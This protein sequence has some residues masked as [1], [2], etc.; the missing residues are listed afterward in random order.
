MLSAMKTTSAAAGGQRDSPKAVSDVA[1]AAGMLAASTGE[2]AQA[3]SHATAARIAVNRE[4]ETK[5]SRMV[6]SAR[7]GS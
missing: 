1:S 4:F 5:A 2:Q 6:S 7:P 3:Y